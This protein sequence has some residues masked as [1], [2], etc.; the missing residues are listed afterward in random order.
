NKLWVYFVATLFGTVFIYFFGTL[1]FMVSTNN[2]NLGPVLMVTMVPFLPLDSVK[3]IVAPLVSFRLRKVLD[4]QLGEVE[5]K[6]TL[7][8]TVISESK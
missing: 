2:F 8:K 1:Y 6:N 5:I 7:N 4:K 3:I